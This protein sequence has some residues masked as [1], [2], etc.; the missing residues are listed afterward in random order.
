M[1]LAATACHAQNLSTAKFNPLQINLPFEISPKGG[2]ALPSAGIKDASFL[3]KGWMAGLDVSL[4]LLQV[5]KS[6]A[7]AFGINLGIDASADYSSF[8]SNGG[9][10]YVKQTYQL[11]NGNLNP[12]FDNSSNKAGVLQFSLGPKVSIRYKR[13]YFTP[14]LQIGYL[15]FQRNGYSILDTVRNAAGSQSTIPLLFAKATNTG[16]LLLRPKI[17]VG[18]DINK[19]VRVW[20]GSSFTEGPN[21]NNEY[22]AW[23][24]N[25]QA[26]PGSITSDELTNGKPVYKD[27][28][29]TFRALSFEFG[30]K[31]GLGVR[32]LS[33]P[34]I[35]FPQSI[36]NS[37][38]YKD[39][40][41]TKGLPVNG[42]AP[43]LKNNGST[44][45]GNS[46]SQAATY[47]ASAPEIT[48]PVFNGKTALIN[49][50]L[51]LT[52][53]ESNTLNVNYVLRIW[54]EKN[55]KQKEI[56]S[57]TY[58]DNWNGTVKDFG[59]L[60]DKKKTDIIYHAQITSKPGNNSDVIKRHRSSA[61]YHSTQQT[62][63]PVFDNGGKSTSV[64][65]S[66]VTGC[67]PE[68][69][70]GLD[71]A[72]CADSN[73][74]K[75]WG[76][77]TLSSGTGVTVSSVTITDFKENNF[78]GAAVPVSNIVPGTSLPP[79][80]NTQ[81]S[82]NVNKDMCG[83]LLFVRVL[84]TYTC[85][86][87]GE[88]VSVP[89]A[90]TISM[91]CCQCSYCTDSMKIQS[92]SSGMTY[93]NA[94]NSAQIIQSFSVTPKNITNVTAEIVYM[95]DSVNDPACQ[96]C[97]TKPVSVYSFSGTNTISWNGNA[98][99]NASA[100]NSANTFPSKI[101]SWQC[102]NNGNI[103]FNLNAGLPDI[104]KLNCCQ[105]TVRIC[106]RYSFTDSN[107]KKC[108][109]LICYSLTYSNNGV[110]K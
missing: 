85:A 88:T 8:T 33:K 102:N 105:R 13:F 38:I 99:I 29:A 98:A 55:G 70:V 81:F 52:F 14:G 56:F 100:A 110:G 106:I 65:F 47:P 59:N 72:R 92:Q 39:E 62:G 34:A 24:L 101:I 71:S 104:P 90:D 41:I 5:G 50:D 82:F 80:N 57:K 66:L 78:S 25:K 1:L 43:E 73:R 67:L 86:L 22:Y 45:N 58:P 84:I 61:D 16:G 40:K 83:K 89:C 69:S 95:S 23:A 42:Q 109:I 7:S 21:I 93:N 3:D 31:L 4:P 11:S 75:V 96:T 79:V 63:I 108:D 60:I 53:K 12:Y 32:P 76:H 54:I 97:D 35:K 9:L 91:P 6:K 44:T 87:T 17:N 27:V 46:N 74:S 94:N 15:H 28:S 18:F 36:P 107:C 49:N 48:Y 30:I 64:P 2:I 68:F 10:S 77:I 103:S 26:Q 51:H 20:A 37:S 19:Y